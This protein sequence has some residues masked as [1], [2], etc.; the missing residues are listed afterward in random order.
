MAHAEAGVAL[1]AAVIAVAEVDTT[2]TVI[3]EAAGVVHITVEVGTAT[4]EVSGLGRDGVD[5][6][7]GGR[8]GARGAFRTIRIRT[9]RHRR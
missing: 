9:I 8:D 4:G 1:M 5:G 2:V 3:A 7:I 6:V